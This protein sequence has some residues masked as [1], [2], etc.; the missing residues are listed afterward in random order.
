MLTLFFTVIFLAELI[1][2]SWIISKIRKADDAILA[3]NKI[4]TEYN[5]Q[6]KNDLQKIKETVITLHSKL[7]CFTTS[8]TNKAENCKKLIKN[9][10]L[11]EFVMWL[12]KIPYKKIITVL[13]IILTIR[14]M[15]K[16]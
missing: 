9:K 13:E 1:V 11:T 14:K 5:P 12:M 2:T 6:L 7:E 10:Y 4:I 3:Y 16:I 15:I 8:V